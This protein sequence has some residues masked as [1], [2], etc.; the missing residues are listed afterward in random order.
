LVLFP[1]NPLTLARYREAFTTSR[2]KDDPSD[3]QLEL[4]LLLKHRDKL[5]R[6]EPQSAEMRALSQLVEDRRTLVN[7]KVRLLNRL[8][9]A[10][11]NYYP[12]PLKWFKET[13][14]ALFCDFLERWPTLKAVQLA[15]RSTLER[16][17]REH[18]VRYSE[19]IDQRLQA[20][21]SATPL[22][23]DEGII[24]PKR[25]VSILAGQKKM[26]HIVKEQKTGC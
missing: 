21:K 5:S 25:L 11:K 8:T 24:M 18:H 10:L 20:I 26:E 1:I 12:Q 17:F 22:T 16:F 6:L 9:S 19:V 2:A 14:T 15:R 13:D 3:A 4:E 7:D 23:T